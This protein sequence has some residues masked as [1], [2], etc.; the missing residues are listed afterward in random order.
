VSN[1]ALNGRRR[2][3]VT[4]L[5]AVTPLGV[6]VESTWENLL[7]GRSGAG[8]ITQFDSSRFSVHFACEVKDFEP[9][10]YIDRKQARRMDRFAHLIVA[11]ARQAE[12]DSGIDIEAEAPRIGAAIATGIGGLKAFQDCHSELLERGPDRVNPFSIPEIIPNMGAAWVSM[13][14]GTKGPLS[15]QCTACAASN[16][17]IGDGLDA[18]RLGRADVMLCGGTEA[19]V[20]EVGIAGF[21]AMRA[22]SRRNDDPEAASRPF[23]AGRDGFVMGEAGAV[24]VLEELEHAKARGAKIYAELLGYG[25]SSDAQH[26]T[27]PDPSGV[28]PAR[29]MEMAFGDASV[30]ADEIDYINAHGTS[31]P[32]GDSAETRVIKLA[33]GEENARETPVSSTKG[34]TGHCLGAAGAVEAMF[35]ILAV[36]R[37]ALPPTINYDEPDPECDL[38]YIPNEAREADVR[39]GVSNSFGFGGHNATIVVRR[40]E[41]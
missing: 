25:V 29:A 37:G 24:V 23:D 28:N 10:E 40:F 3:V 21:S 9:T 35:T 11:A 7:A 19:P 34:A 32:L 17:A 41:D 2:V 1:G 14:L 39:T 18:I 5:G 31:T 4:G 36:N 20:T 13:Q 26:I 27:E 8:E 12:K 15:S 6:D 33:L 16:M 22:L 30:N 38:D